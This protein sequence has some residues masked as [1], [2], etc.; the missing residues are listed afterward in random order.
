LGMLFYTGANFPQ[1]YLLDAFICEHGSWN[2]EIPIGFF[3]F[4]FKSNKSANI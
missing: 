4:Q 2:R 3:S 1:D